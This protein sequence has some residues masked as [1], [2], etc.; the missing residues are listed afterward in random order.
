MTGFGKEGDGCRSKSKHSV[1]VESN[2]YVKS[3]KEEEFSFGEAKCEAPVSHLSETGPPLVRTGRADCT[4]LW[5]MTFGCNQF[6]EEKA[7][8]GALKRLDINA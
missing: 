4:N 5:V 8:K 6:M 2:Y 1:L 7:F 3:V